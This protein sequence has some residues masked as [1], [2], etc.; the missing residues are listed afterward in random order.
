MAEWQR[1]SRPPART[2]LLCELATVAAAFTAGAWSRDSGTCSM[3]GLRPS[4]GST[5]NWKVQEH[6][7][8]PLGLLCS[9]P[10]TQECLSVSTFHPPSSTPPLPLASH[11]SFCLGPALL[12]PPETEGLGLVAIATAKSWR[13]QV[14]RNQTAGSRS[15]V[16]A[17]TELGFEPGPAHTALSAL[18]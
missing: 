11:L 8:E 5:P 18:S 15:H 4:V 2:G 14:W 12:A 10:P 9:C 6:G 7:F 13:H 3:P 1:G 16:W 17:D